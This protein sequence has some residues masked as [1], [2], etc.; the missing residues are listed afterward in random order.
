MFI[1]LTTSVPFSTGHLAKSRSLSTTCLRSVGSKL[2]AETQLVF[3]TQI[4]PSEPCSS[5]E[6]TLLPVDKFRTTSPSL[7]CSQG[8][9]NP[10][11]RR[12]GTRALS[13][14]RCSSMLLTAQK[15]T[16]FCD[17]EHIEP[18]AHELTEHSIELPFSVADLLRHIG[19]GVLVFLLQSIHLFDQAIDGRLR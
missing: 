18:V 2:L 16:Q 13:G 19:I 6:L 5:R 9:L 12:A 17:T 3:R 15:L 8:S 4:S 14:L 7:R 1:L 10:S 11:K